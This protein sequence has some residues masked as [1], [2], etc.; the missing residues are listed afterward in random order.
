[1]STY[2]GGEVGKMEQIYNK[3]YFGE[4]L[5]DEGQFWIK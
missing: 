3:L 5:T 4:P 2:L 1:M